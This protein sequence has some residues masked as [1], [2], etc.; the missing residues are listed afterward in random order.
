M[1]ILVFNS[2]STSLKYKLFSRHS[3]RILG[4]GN[5]QNL[6]KQS[7]YLFVLKGIL[8]RVKGLHDIEI[9]GH[10]IVHGGDKF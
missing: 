4:R 2:G 8:E 1:S 3:L 6:N 5:F 9:V 10:R 7:D